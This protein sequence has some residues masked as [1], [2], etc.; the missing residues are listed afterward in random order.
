[1]SLLTVAGGSQ[2][3]A[4]RAAVTATR[5]PGA[6]STAASASSASAPM[7]PEEHHPPGLPGT[8]W[9]S[10]QCLPTR[11]CPTPGRPRLRHLDRRG[12]W[13]HTPDTLVARSAQRPG[14]GGA[15]MQSHSIVA[16]QQGSQ[17]R[18][19]PQRR[20]PLAVRRTAEVRPPSQVLTPCTECEASTPGVPPPRTW[21]RPGPHVR[22]VGEPWGGPRCPRD[23]NPTQ[24]KQHGKGW[25]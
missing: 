23:A 7:R 12:R 19:S 25:S 6:V 1:M 24:R 11:P 8:P 14:A 15:Q 3:P 16:N 9:G 4:S 2:P 17:V 10:L 21:L 22:I 5:Q 13:R 18:L 20:G